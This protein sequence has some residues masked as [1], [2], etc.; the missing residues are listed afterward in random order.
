MNR[1]PDLEA[2]ITAGGVFTRADADRVMAC[3][4]LISVGLLGEAAR[5][6]LHG[7]RVT[8]GRVCEAGPGPLPEACG[9][10][11]EIR[12]MGVPAS[13]DDARERVRLA[14]RAADGVPLTGFSLADLLGLVAGDHLAL[15]EL[16]RTLRA[17]GLEAVA[18]V[19]LDRLGPVEDAAE[20]VRAVVHGGLGAWRATIDRATPAGRVDV[21]ERA[22]GVQRETGAFKSFAPLPRIDSPESPST[23]YD[24]VR[25]IAVARLLCQGI[26]S[27]QVD[28]RLYGPKLAQVALAYGADDLD[29]VPATDAPDLG[30]RRA[31]AADLE[32]QI[33][34]AF[35]VPAERNGRFEPR[36]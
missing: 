20:V 2:K 5:K 14:R 17:D 10:A 7:D 32:R 35:A 12:L 15:V 19:P 25:T 30:P 8:Y 3:P 29:A 24:D 4:D 34:A 13:I 33:Q 23:G 21:I 11:G 28:W 16:A 31:P 6:R 27:I 9:P 1:L 18:E 26:P 22:A 36:R